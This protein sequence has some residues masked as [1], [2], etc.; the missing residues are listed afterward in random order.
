MRRGPEEVEELV[1][2]MAVVVVWQG[3]K[4]REGGAWMMLTLGWKKSGGELKKGSRSC[5]SSMRRSGRCTET[6]YDIHDGPFDVEDEKRPRWCGSLHRQ[7]HCSH[8]SLALPESLP[9]ST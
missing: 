4:R 8:T 9:W 7:L 2:V 6:S 5:G 3:G 1:A